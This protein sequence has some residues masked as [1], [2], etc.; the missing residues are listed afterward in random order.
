MCAEGHSFGSTKQRYLSRTE[1][2]KGSL[3]PRDFLGNFR[4]LKCRYC[5]MSGLFLCVGIPLQSPEIEALYMV[6]ISNLG[7]R[8]GY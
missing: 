5:T 1:T 8:S 3:N 4:T 7:P 6:G 2:S